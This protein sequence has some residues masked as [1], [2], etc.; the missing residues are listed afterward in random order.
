MMS[1]VSKLEAYA[2]QWLA[3]KGNDVAFISKELKIEEQKVTEIL[4]K[5]ENVDNSNKIKTGSGSVKAS[6]KT[7]MVNETAVK[8]TKSVSIMTEAASQKN[9]EILKNMPPVAKH[10][11]AIFRP[12][13]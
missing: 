10:H 13:G 6:E 3:Y 2:V 5:C 11:D 12:H 8:K 1:R 9:D 7:L 4:E